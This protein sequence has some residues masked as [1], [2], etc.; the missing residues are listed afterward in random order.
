MTSPQAPESA[1]RYSFTVYV[2]APGTPIHDIGG[3]VEHSVPGHLYWSISDGQTTT[4]YGFAPATPGATNGAG[5]ISP[6]DHVRYQNPMY[7]RQFAISAEQYAQLKT[8]GERTRMDEDPRFDLHY[9]DAR[10]NCVDY[11]WA[12]LNVA[13]INQR[14]AYEQGE[15]PSIREVILGPNDQFRRDGRLRP[16]DNARDLDLLRDPIPNHPLNETIRRDPPVLDGFNFIRRALSDTDPRDPSHPDHDRFQRIEQLVYAEDTRRGRTPDERSDNLVASLTVLSKRS[17]VEPLNLAFSVEDKS[18]AL[19]AGQNVFL[20][21]GDP[22]REPWYQRAAMPTEQ[23]I[24]TPVA[25]SFRE[26]EVV[27]RQMAQQQTDAMA[28]SRSQGLQPEGQAPSGPRM[29]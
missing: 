1:S 2:A 4:G 17:G 28:F 8:F 6:N 16:I 18:R 26:L 29:A 14:R 3:S 20:Y 11:T 25:E 10:N 27:N 19:V 15:T 7:E 24:R 9:R 23:A 13:G 5:E 21:D 12:A 22:V